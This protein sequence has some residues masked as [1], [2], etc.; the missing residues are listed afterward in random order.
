MPVLEA[1]VAVDTAELVAQWHGD[2]D[3]CG[4]WHPELV[5]KACDLEQPSSELFALRIFYPDAFTHEV[6]DD[7]VEIVKQGWAIHVARQSLR[8]PRGRL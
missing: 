3:T 8:K 6:D 4:Y 2:D 1:P 7:A 5:A